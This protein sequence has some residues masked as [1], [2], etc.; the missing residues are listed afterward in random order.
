MFLLKWL[1]LLCCCFYPSLLKVMSVKYDVI[2]VGGGPAG[3]HV[4]LPL[5]KA[6][7][8]VG[9][10]DGGVKGVD[11]FDTYDT[12]D[13]ESIRRN[14]SDQHE[15]FLGKDISGAVVLDEEDHVSQMF[16]GRFAYAGEGAK[17]AL[18]VESGGF[19][20]VQTLAKGGMTEVWGAVSD[21]VTRS[22]LETLG[23]PGPQVEPHYQ[24]VIDEIGI[25]GPLRG[26]RTLPP[27][28]LSTHAERIFSKFRAKQLSLEAL[29]LSL[30][31]SALAI[32]TQ[33]MRGRKATSYSD[34]EYWLDKSRSV[35]RA[36]YTIE[37]LEQRSNFY[38]LP[39]QVASSVEETNSGVRIHAANFDGAKH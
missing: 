31:Q 14:R 10:I 27:A 15:F 17:N 13:F 11:S 3:A 36:R 26:Y 37:E 38:Y 24:D 12:M 4:A 21:V 35:Y 5:V 1:W 16:T 22:E 2:I 25:S 9:M 30:E 28:K 34:T 33:D 39:L 8:Q 32:L 20:I 6:G 23:L 19:E 18:P 29:D 7:L